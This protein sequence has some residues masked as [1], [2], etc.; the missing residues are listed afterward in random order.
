MEKDWG[1]II[2]AD[3]KPDKMVNRQAQKAHVKL[4]QFNSTFA[5]RGKTWINIYKTYVRAFPTVH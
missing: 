1:V 2:S 4:L 3:L 5:Y